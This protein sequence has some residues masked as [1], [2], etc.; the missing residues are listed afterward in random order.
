MTPGF[1]AKDYGWAALTAFAALMLA[2][3]VFNAF[4]QV[5]TEG[6]WSALLGV[7]IATLFWFWIGAGAWRRTRWGA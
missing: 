6:A 1:S 4:W 5:A 7:P 2:A 3:S